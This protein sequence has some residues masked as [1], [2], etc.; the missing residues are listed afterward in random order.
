MNATYTKKAIA[1]LDLIHTGRQF[2][3]TGQMRN[4][5]AAERL[6]DFEVNH[7][8]WFLTSTGCNVLAIAHHDNTIATHCTKCNTP[9][10]LTEFFP[11]NVCLA[12]WENSPAGRYMPTGRELAQMWGAK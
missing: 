3:V 12:C 5:L 9:T 7:N 1:A 8:G 10:G 11:G 2:E 6:I 4:R